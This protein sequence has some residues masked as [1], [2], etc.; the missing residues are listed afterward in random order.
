MTVRWVG[1]VAL[2]M[3]IGCSASNND[4]SSSQPDQLDQVGLANI[5]GYQDYYIGRFRS[6][7]F[8]PTDYDATDAYPLVI[9]L[10]GYN[11]LT[12][13][14]LEWYFEPFLSADPAIVITPKCPT[15]EIAGW[16]DSWNTELS[17]MMSQAYDMI[18]LIL[19]TFNIDESRIYIYGTSMGGFGTYAAIRHT[20]DFFAAAYVAAGGG[21]T[22]MAEII[23]SMPFW[24]FHGDQDDVVSVNYSRD[25]VQ[26]VVAVGGETIRYTEYKG[27]AH[28]VWDYTGQEETL[29]IWL[30][31]Q[32]KG[33]MHREPYTQVFPQYTFEQSGVLLSWEISNAFPV[34]DDDIWFVRILRNGDLLA[35][36]NSDT[37]SF[38]DLSVESE[39]TYEYEFIAVNYFFKKGLPETILVQFP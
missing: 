17:P 1:I 34:S 33:S 36:I 9:R 30:I 31:S 23:N 7:V 20:P 10:H 19:G 13:W 2:A 4:G 35:E 39:E 3:L 22:A 8:V 21:N 29:P 37:L 18:S 6:G 24:I 14:D 15:S 5:R 16:G 28:N 12:N 26:A 38:L 25:M 27:V 32:R 11:D